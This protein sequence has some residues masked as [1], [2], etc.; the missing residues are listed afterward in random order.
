MAEDVIARVKQANDIVEVVREYLPLRRQGRTYKGLCPFHDDHHPSL[1]VDP[2]RQRFR[3]WACGKYGDV[4]TFVQERE[5]CSFR[6]A[7]ELLARRAGIAIHWG[8]APRDQ[9][10]ATWFELLRWAEEQFRKCFWE[11][12]QA[13]GARQYL[14][15][16]GFRRETL[17]EFGIGF[18]PDDWEWLTRRGL[19]LGWTTEQLVTVGL[20][21]QREQDGKLYD[22]FRGR[23]MFPIR[24]V[25]GRTVGFGGRI[26]P[27]TP[28]EAHQ[29]KYYNSTD[30]PLFRKSEH[31]YGLDV[32]RNAAEQS[33]YLAVV[34]GYTDVLM[35]HQC[36]C[37]AVVATLGTALNAAHVQ[38]LRRFAP[39]IVLVFDADSGGQRGV[40]S[41]LQ[42]FLQH[43]VDLAIAQL[44]APF[45]PCDYLQAHGRE[46]FEQ[47]V[48]QAVDAL[49]FRLRQELTPQAL[50]SLEGRRQ[51][52]ENVLRVLAQLPA[53]STGTVQV[54][55]ELAVAHL[56]RRTGI[57][58]PSLW[59][60][61]QEIYR[62]THHLPG[63]PQAEPVRVHVS[64]LE[65][66]LLEI[67]LAEPALLQEFDNQLPV[68]LV[69]H[70]GI[71]QMLA[72]ML[73][74]W[75]AGEVPHLERM[76]QEFADQPRLC[77]YLLQLHDRGLA[78]ADRRSCLQDVLQALREREA[79]RQRERLRSELQN[80]SGDAPPPTDLL[81][82]YQQPQP[83]T[84]SGP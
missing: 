35:A 31:L 70:R 12:S 37:R 56:A 16:R 38:Q 15:E 45:D 24:D 67:L 40:D 30:T 58:A 80:I 50:A 7:V 34:E 43:E 18:A 76:R 25:R 23:I 55:R 81:R 82:Q 66:Q 2:L 32:A 83:L 53:N 62:Q 49:E 27:G 41:A 22:R 68:E 8:Q 29:P 46:A 20:C 33:G 57:S 69:E 60:R 71:R 77:T 1:D 10:R 59:L 36:G 75:R 11:S 72:R 74:I 54:K 65:R 42:L 51:A 26:L 52:A 84:S 17:I 6:E 63:P 14:Q 3:C 44:P 9:E 48:H 73:R 78:L 39:R 47:V 13:A 21:G 64:P 28:A 61:L 4:I 79:R 19:R 5:R